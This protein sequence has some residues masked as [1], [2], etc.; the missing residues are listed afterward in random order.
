[1]NRR[2]FIRVAGG[3]VAV[4]L[5]ASA[6]APGQR[7]DIATLAQTELL[8]AFGPALVREVGARYRAMVPVE[9]D[10]ASLRAAIVASTPWTSRLPWSRQLVVAELVRLDF[11]RGHTVVVDG[12]ILSATEARQ[13][14]LYSLIPG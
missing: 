13:C 1:M 9:R 8:G 10:T 2:E 7:Y 4:A 3:G 12:W 14:A 5:T 11:E 6:C